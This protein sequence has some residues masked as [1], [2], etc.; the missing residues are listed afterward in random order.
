[1]AVPRHPAQNETFEDDADERLLSKTRAP[2]EEMP[3]SSFTS[4]NV[5]SGLY[6]FGERELFMRYLRTV[7]P[8]AIYRYDG[9]P[10][11]EWQGLK[12]A[13]SKGSYINANVAF[14]YF[15]TRINRGEI[16]DEDQQAAPNT[17]VRRF[18]STP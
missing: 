10:A 3:T 1:M 13:R 15:Y 11:S 14:D 2:L 7:G 16:P 17:L 12:Q 5:H 4:S 18:I 8:D 9:V 6:D